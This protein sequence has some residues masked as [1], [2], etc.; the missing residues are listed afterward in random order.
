MDHCL[1]LHFVLYNM[2]LVTTLIIALYGA[3][4][5]SL[6]M[7]N[8][9]ALYAENINEIKTNELLFTLEVSFSIISK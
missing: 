2:R 9:I 6:L 8:L 4:N 7:P 1:C 5:Y 3:M